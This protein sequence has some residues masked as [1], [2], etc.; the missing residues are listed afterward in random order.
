MSGFSAEWLRL[1]EP[2]DAAARSP[3]LTARLIAWRRRHDALSV[4]DLGGGTGANF[5]FLSPA[6]GGKQRWW[7]LD[8]DPALLAR[9]G[10]LLCQ[11]AVKRGMT[12]TGEGETLLL[13]DD[14]NHYRLERLC[15]D[16]NE[17]WEQ[18]AVVPNMRLVTASALI[19]L[20]SADWLARLARRCRTWR[21]AV[22]IVLSYD[23]SIVW[24]PAMEDD[25]R[26][27]EW[28]NR[29]QCTDKGFGSALG[30]DAASALVDWLERLD[31]RVVLRPSPWT[32]A[33]QDAVLQTALLDGWTKAVRQIAPETKSW[34]D[35]WSRHRRELIERGH[36]HLSVGHWDL[37]ASLE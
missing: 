18:L 16:L 4:L 10:E 2:A 1:R 8:H 20:V 31:Y 30:P 6:L 37:F 12:A 28:V 34:L 33:A 9:A 35:A 36:S 14:A 21:A 26:V 19:D 15:L 27:R 11:W 5:R 23:G 24:E 22:L 17:D 29:H 13:E 32:L 3:A 25:E 7:L